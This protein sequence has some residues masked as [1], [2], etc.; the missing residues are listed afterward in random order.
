MTSGMFVC[1]GPRGRICLLLLLLSLGL[2]VNGAAA[3]ESESQS[4]DSSGSE[5]GSG[6]YED[7]DA[8]GTASDDDEDTSSDTGSETSSSG[9]GTSRSLSDS[10]SIRSFMTARSAADSSEDSDAGGGAAS[11]AVALPA[12]PPTPSFELLSATAVLFSE[13]KETSFEND[14]RDQFKSIAGP[15]ERLKARA[16][17][18]PET[19]QLQTLLSQLRALEKV[20]DGRLTAA[21]PADVAQSLVDAVN[22]VRKLVPDAKNLR[23]TLPEQGGL[24]ENPSNLP[25]EV[26]QNALVQRAIK[27]REIAAA[28][29]ALGREPREEAQ[30]LRETIQGGAAAA[31]AQP[32][33]T[34]AQLDA[35]I[36]KLDSLEKSMLGYAQA[37]E[38]VV[39][40]AI[41]SYPHSL[42]GARTQALSGPDGG[43]SAGA[44]QNAETRSLRYDFDNPDVVPDPSQPP[45]AVFKAEVPVLT[46]DAGLLAQ[47]DWNHTDPSGA[48]Y[49]RLAMPPLRLSM[50]AKATEMVAKVLGLNTYDG[51]G[52][53][54][55]LVVRTELVADGG[56]DGD[57]GVV[58]ARA[59]GKQPV[60]YIYENMPNPT[61]QEVPTEAKI[62]IDKVKT[63]RERVQETLDLA[64][65]AINPPVTATTTTTTPASTTV[66]QEQLDA[67][68][69]GAN[70][71][72]SE[73][74]LKVA[75]PAIKA[76]SEARDLLRDALVQTRI[77]NEGTPQA[78]AQ[79]AVAVRD[80]TQAELDDP[81]VR[82]ALS[83]AQLLDSLC[84]QVD[85][86]M[87]NLFIDLTRTPP[88]A[89]I[90][91]DQ[92][93]G[94]DNDSYKIAD[95][96]PGTSPWLRALPKAVDRDLAQRLLD[97]SADDL[98]AA[99][100]GLLTTLEQDALVGRL[101]T[102]KRYL[103]GE[104]RGPVPR[105]TMDG[106]GDT[107]SW[108]TADPGELFHNASGQRGGN[109]PTINSYYGYLKGI[110]ERP[111][112]PVGPPPPL[113]A[114]PPPPLPADPLPPPPADPPPPPLPADTS[115]P[116]DELSQEPPPPPL[117]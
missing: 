116:D 60:S 110:E 29:N 103:N 105:V 27:A 80:I 54:A 114:D 88:V 44:G 40:Q 18:R 104:L 72:V 53:N 49:A 8:S 6:S 11:A 30:A 1:A 38:D 111:P 79:R 48:A 7:T 15:A 98:R 112:L 42:A 84:G 101:E 69:D 94:L 115:P 45:N 62:H 102:I 117:P 78:I 56:K 70:L 75:G 10:Q 50:R 65:N 83:N 9:T 82:Q 35:R 19:E 89:L 96:V 109:F 113:P 37:V 64:L 5:S 66:T 77:L 23:G 28:V 100:I 52:A 2:G 47:L 63:R 24:S 76:Y 92:A 90:D 20:D 67:Y 17:R 43:A 16:G 108:N 32:S 12:G 58:M 87:Q 3:S 71:P 4:S 51:Q 13:Q 93:F 34:L 31:A 73:N 95:D 46:Q 97:T 14:A 107:L 86:H 36:G 68:L 22:G 57:F 26:R 81:R 59:T 25:A 99:T 21:L 39:G 106:T 74:K 91:N 61:G 41:A 33:K 85:R 55:G